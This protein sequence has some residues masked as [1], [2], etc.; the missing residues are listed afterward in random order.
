MENN[1]K[2]IRL[3]LNWI[4]TILFLIFLTVKLFNPTYEWLTL[5]WVFFPLWS[6]IALE[7]VIAGSILLVAFILD[8]IDAR[9]KIK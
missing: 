6:P 3:S 2:R 7:L 8:R 1:V 4:G 5:F 9:S